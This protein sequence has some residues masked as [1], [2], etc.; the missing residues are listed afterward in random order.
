MFDVTGLASG[1]CRQRFW[2]LDKSV[3]QCVSPVTQSYPQKATLQPVSYH[4]GSNTPPNCKFYLHY[5]QKLYNLYAKVFSW[6]NRETIYTLLYRVIK[7][8]CAPDDYNTES[9]K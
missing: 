4:N 7:S 2:M 8:L 5:S 6:E 9:Y 3:H 1:I